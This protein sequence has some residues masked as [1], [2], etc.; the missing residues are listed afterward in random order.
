MSVDGGLTWGDAELGE[1]VGRH[2]WRAWQSEW[3]P[4]EPG[5]YE[6]RCRAEDA[7]GN[8]QP[9]EPAWN[10]KGYANNAAQR[11]AVVVAEPGGPGAGGA[12]T[13]PRRG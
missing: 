7:A 4:A 11:V 5:R 13:P 12:L 10:L 1:A 6:L 9:D 2:A 3:K 8:R